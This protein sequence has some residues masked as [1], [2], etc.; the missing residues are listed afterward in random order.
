MRDAYILDLHASHRAAELPGDRLGEAVAAFKELHQRAFG[1]KPPITWMAVS[2]SDGPVARSLGL[3]TGYSARLC[4][5]DVG[6]GSGLASLACAARAVTSGFESVAAAVSYGTR[7]QPEWGRASGAVHAGVGGQTQAHAL[8]RS[9]L[10]AQD[11]IDRTEAAERPVPKPE[12]RS[13]RWVCRVNCHTR[14]TRP[15][16]V[17]SCWRGIKR[18]GNTT[19]VR[20]RASRV[21]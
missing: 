14:P 9:E 4:A 5:R 19:G 17:W 3:L 18:F 20:V 13:C 8:T 7:S 6:A 16:S 12:T 21:S 10:T 2:T 15:V 1:D 11:V